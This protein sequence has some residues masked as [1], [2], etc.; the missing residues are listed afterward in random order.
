MTRKFYLDTCVWCRPFDRPA[1]ERIILESAAVKGVINRVDSGEVVILASSILF[2]EASLISQGYKRD[3]VREFIS[4]SIAEIAP[5]TERSEELANEIM[6]DYNIS[7]MDA[8]HLA[9]AIDNEV[10]V[11]LTTDDKILKKADQISKY[12]I[13]VKNPGEVF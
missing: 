5:V 13:E 11:F 4:R 2:L 7:A 12:G 10:E 1:N 9:I 6:E 3:A 8:M